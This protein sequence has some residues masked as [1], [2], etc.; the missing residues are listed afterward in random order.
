LDGAIVLQGLGHQRHL[1]TIGV[2]RMRTA[3]ALPE[4]R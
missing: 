2:V 4:V 3:P 1:L